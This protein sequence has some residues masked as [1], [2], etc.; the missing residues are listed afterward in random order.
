MIHV[1]D[2]EED[3]ARSDIRSLETAFRAL[4]SYPREETIEGADSAHHLSELLNRVAEA[5]QF[6][7]SLMPHETFDILD[8]VMQRELLPKFSG[9]YASGSA[10]VRNHRDHFQ[11]QFARHLD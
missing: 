1:A 11:E 8:E 10:V 2:I 3:L 6:D 4:V 9:D 5:L 7:T